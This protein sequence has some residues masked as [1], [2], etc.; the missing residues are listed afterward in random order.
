L[1]NV[2]YRAA[3]ATFTIEYVA[4]LRINL[5]HRVAYR[6]E[7]IEESALPEKLPGMARRLVSNLHASLLLTP[8]ERI[9]QNPA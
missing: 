9:K 3:L 2:F 1:F 5:D 6:Q 8:P 7:L 4:T